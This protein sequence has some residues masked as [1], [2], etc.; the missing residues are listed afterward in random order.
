M[1]ASMLRLSFTQKMAELLQACHL[2]C[3]LSIKRIARPFALHL[4][5]LKKLCCL[6]RWI[7]HD[8]PEEFLLHSG[9]NLKRVERL[10][11]LKIVTSLDRYR[12]A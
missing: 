1:F 11:S 3:W 9:R 7:D 2:T 4:A 12:E 5:A 6:P 8:C 10:P